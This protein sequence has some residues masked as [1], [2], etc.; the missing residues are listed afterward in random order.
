MKRIFGIATL[1]IA[2]LTGFTLGCQT[3]EAAAESAAEAQVETATVV[4][5]IDGMSCVSCA[6]AIEGEFDDAE[7]IIDGNVDFGED[8]ATVEYDPEGIDEAGIIELIEDAGFDAVVV[9]D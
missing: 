5:E 6:R 1:T 4:V 7:A 2:L 8:R 3:G 9:D